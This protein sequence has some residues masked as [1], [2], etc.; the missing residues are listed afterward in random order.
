M[1]IEWIKNGLKKPEKSA[2]GLARAMGIHPSQITRILARDKKARKIKVDEVEV[3]AKYLEE[4]APTDLRHS[5]IPCFDPDQPDPSQEDETPAISTQGRRHLSPGAVAEFN[6]RGQ[7]SYGGGY[8]Q[9]S[10][11]RDEMGRSFAAE[12]VQ[13]EWII[14]PSYLQ[15]ELR[16]KVET[17]DILPID[18]PSMIPD[19]APG[20]RVMIDRSHRDPRQGGIFAVREGDGIIIKHVEV[21]R[22][23]D[24]P[25]IMCSSSN[26]AYHPFELVLDGESVA[27]IGRVAGRISRM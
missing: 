3:I 2:T 1:Y 11:I 22:N 21:I 5:L 7:A 17:T 25:R 23:T 12:A 6:L 10:E 14:P 18:G 27:I 13:A 16:L 15:G 20:D 19:L 9:P 24:P 4:P 26:P 8:A